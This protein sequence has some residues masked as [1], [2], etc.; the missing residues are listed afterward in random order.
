MREWLS[1]RR[2]MAL[3]VG[4]VL[5]ATVVIGVVWGAA[6][7][8]GVE[9][10][11]TT[12]ALTSATT[13]TVQEAES[14]STFGTATTTTLSVTTSSPTD[15]GSATT[16]SGG[17]TS[18]AGAGSGGGSNPTTTTTANQPPIIEDPGITS[19]GMRLNVA[20][21]IADP[22]SD[23]L[24]IDISAEPGGVVSCDGCPPGPIKGGQFRYD[25]AEVGFAS[26]VVVSIRVAD[27]AGNE[28]VETF[29]HR[30]LAISTVELRANFNMTGASACF[31]DK[32]AVRLAGE[33]EAGGSISDTFSFSEE[34]RPDRTRILIVADSREIVGE[35]PSPL[36]VSFNGELDEHVDST[37]REFVRTDQVIENLFTNQSCRGSLIWTVDLDVR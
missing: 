13:T 25:P 27:G 20:P 2:R 28:T 3:L 14:T 7:A 16:A 11:A 6:D 12:T 17:G 35:G 22:D 1:D 4:T 21:L 31:S 34:L 30:L 37:E 19:T 33:I 15:F 36:T 10:T 24:T 26:D 5:A 23:A 9:A 29:E 32:A 18:G 8:G